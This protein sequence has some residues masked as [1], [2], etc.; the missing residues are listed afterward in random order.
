[1]HP[2][3]VAQVL[4]SIVRKEIALK[5]VGG[6][7]VILLGLA[8]LTA[9][10]WIVYAAIWLGF[11][12]LLPHSHEVR[13]LVSSVVVVLLFIGNARTSQEY[14]QQ[15]KI[16]TD[17]GKEGYTI[18]VPDV[19]I[20]TNVNFFSLNTMHSFTKVITDLLYVGPRL[21]V[22]GYRAFRNA[23]RLKEMDVEGCAGILFLL[24][25]REG[26]ISFSEILKLAPVA[27]PEKVIPQMAYIDGVLFMKSDPPGLTLGSELRERL[28]EETSKLGA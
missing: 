17:D 15:Y 14:L 22:A 16:D 1:M 12:W 20:F 8:V 23:A 27:D 19:G 7:L 21:V 11:R 10:F 26:R 18:Y 5:I 6:V 25:A 3:R 4:A 24:L 9:T 2:Q 13:L 28:T